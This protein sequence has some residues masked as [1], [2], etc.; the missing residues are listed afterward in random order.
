MPV[1]LLLWQ[2][3]RGVP[4]FWPS[5]SLLFG[6]ASFW[7]LLSSC[8]SLLLVR[9]LFVEKSLTARCTNGRSRTSGKRI[10]SE[11][12]PA[13]FRNY[14]SSSST[15]YLRLHL[16]A[17]LNQAGPFAAPPHSHLAQVRFLFRDLAF[18]HCSKFRRI[19]RHVFYVL[20]VPS[21]CN[22]HETVRGLDDRRI[23]VPGRQRLVLKRE[24]V[25]PLHSVF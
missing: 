15:R 2:R 1:S 20:S 23:R 5:A 9:F 22:S 24:N 25:R 17:H 3:L 11:M 7:Q 18:G 19:Y 10:C 14:R 13:S 16:M 6:D 4:G 8:S 12:S 21:V